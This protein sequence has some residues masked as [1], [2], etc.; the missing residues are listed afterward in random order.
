MMFLWIPFLFLPFAVF[1]LLR[2]GMGCGI[3]HVHGAPYPGMPQRS[4]PDAVEILRMRLARGE[5]TA[6]EYD[7]I[8]AAL[9]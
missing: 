5:I 4:E 3:G 1:W 2:P 8:R 7:E 6:A 9:G